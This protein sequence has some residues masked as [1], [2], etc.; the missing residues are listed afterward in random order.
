MDEFLIIENN[1]LTFRKIYL[2][3][4]ILNNL[5]ENINNKEKKLGK[6][7]LISKSLEKVC[8]ED[9]IVE[10]LKKKSKEDIIIKSLEKSN[11]E[12]V[13]LKNKLICKENNINEE[14]VLEYKENEKKTIKV[15]NEKKAINNII[16]I[17]KT[18]LDNS[19]VVDIIINGEIIEE[20]NNK[21]RLDNIYNEKYKKGKEDIDVGCG[22]CCI[23]LGNVCSYMKYE[24]EKMIEYIV[25]KCSKNDNNLKKE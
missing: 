8:Q 25:N 18:N 14:K 10:P 17:E 4:M 7:N 15:L 22:I 1:K 3:F 16:N 11:E 2:K 20:I 13:I 6:K 23:G 5:L 9:I 21:E 24:F 19:K 12:D